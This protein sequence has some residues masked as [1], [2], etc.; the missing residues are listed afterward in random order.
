[1]SVRVLTRSWARATRSLYPEQLGHARLLNQ[2]EDIPAEERK[3][4]IETGL[5][6]GL[7]PA[8]GA[9]Y[10]HP[11]HDAPKFLVFIW[12]GNFT[13]SLDG[14]AVSKWIGEMIVALDEHVPNDEVDIL[15][16]KS[17]SPAIKM[18]YSGA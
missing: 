10:S 13:T 12:D 3:R 14:I 8:L 1:M 11:Y 16:A 6:P 9:A 2:L 4:R 7:F 5:S 15:W 17:S 18:P